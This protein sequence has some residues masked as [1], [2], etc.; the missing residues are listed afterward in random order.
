MERK[1]SEKTRLEICL[2]GRQGSS[3]WLFCIQLTHH[4][5]DRGISISEMLVNFYESTQHTSKKPVISVNFVAY[6]DD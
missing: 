5:D 1:G 3:R 2:E 6:Y 4:L